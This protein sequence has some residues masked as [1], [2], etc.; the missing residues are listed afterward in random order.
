MDSRSVQDLCCVTQAT[1]F[2][3]CLSEND[4][5]KLGAWTVCPSSLGFSPA[6][7]CRASLHKACR[8]DASVA[9]RVTDLLD[10][11]H[12]DSVIMVR[13]LHEEQLAEA[14][15]RWLEQPDGRALPGL[16][17]ALCTD[18]R[19]EVHV[20]GIRLCHEAVT[21]ACREFVEAASF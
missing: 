9:Q 21:F 11:A 16:L 15:S 7:W 8:C 12:M 19:P 13:G 14:V 2:N 18:A 20:L 17:W 6:V 3:V 1:L 10:L 5:R 4:L